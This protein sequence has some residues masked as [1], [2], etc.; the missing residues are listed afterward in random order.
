MKET[1]LG[2]SPVRPAG[3][4]SVGGALRLPRPPPPVA[5]HHA[6][7]E[8][9]HARGVREVRAA[10]A[11][12]AVAGEGALEAGGGGGG[13][14]QQQRRRGGAQRR[15][16]APGP[17]AVKLQLYTEVAQ[18]LVLMSAGR[19]AANCKTFMSPPPPT[20]ARRLDHRHNG[21]EGLQKKLFH[22]LATCTTCSPTKLEATLTKDVLTIWYSSI[23][24]GLCCI[25]EHL[26]LLTVTI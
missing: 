19:G 1:C 11:R 6:R 18:E 22:I 13:G 20:G 17:A 3:T 25:F 26:N 16:H 10:G 2:W 23:I 8:V 21:M 14:Q 15:R 4:V 7:A 5:H 9:A 24:S 12:Q